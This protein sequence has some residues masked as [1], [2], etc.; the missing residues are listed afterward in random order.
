MP[1]NFILISEAILYNHLTNIIKWEIST[2][3]VLHPLR[4]NFYAPVLLRKFTFQKVHGQYSDYFGTLY[5]PVLFAFAVA[6]TVLNSMQVEMA[7]E[8]VSG[9]HGEVLWSVCRW[10]RRNTP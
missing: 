4:L 1:P 9:A 10:T 5:G 2:Y 8:Q 6:S 3:I 7:V